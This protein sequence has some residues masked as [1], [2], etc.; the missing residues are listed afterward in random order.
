[1]QSTLMPMG[2]HSLHIQHTHNYQHSCSHTAYHIQYI[3]SLIRFIIFSIIFLYVSHVTTSLTSPY[4]KSET[5]LWST[6]FL[7]V[8][9]LILIEK[10]TKFSDSLR[11]MFC[12]HPGPFKL[13]RVY[14]ISPQQ[15]HSVSCK[16]VTPLLYMSYL[17]IS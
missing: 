5:L 6:C 10:F 11:K 8:Q 7:P 12:I 14:L 1:M 16:V 9:V 15:L 2:L 17:R 13:A 3:L 4:P